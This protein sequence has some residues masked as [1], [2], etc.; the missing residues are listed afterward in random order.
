MPGF[1]FTESG[2]RARF[3]GSDMLLYPKPISFKL[4]ESSR[5]TAK[6]SGPIQ[7][8]CAQGIVTNLMSPGVEAYFPNSA[9]FKIKSIRGPILTVSDASYGP[10]TSTP[11][12]KWILLTFGDQQPPILFSFLG[13]QC[14]LVVQGKS[15][16]WSLQTA[17]PFVGWIRISLPFGTQGISANGPS[18]LGELAKTLQHQSTLWTQPTPRMVSRQIV[19]TDTSV[20]VRMRFDRASSLVPP[21]LILS[22]LGGYKAKIYSPVSELRAWNEN[23]PIVVTRTKELVFECPIQAISPGRPLTLGSASTLGATNEGKASIARVCQL[24]L[25]LLTS[26]CPE[27]AVDQ[28]RKMLS[29][30][31]RVD[32]NFDT[33]AADSLLWRGLSWNSKSGPKLV[34]ERLNALLLELDPLTFCFLGTDKNIARRASGICAISA[35]LDSKPEINFLGAMLQMGMRA[36][37]VL[38]SFWKAKSLDGTEVSNLEPMSKL[39]NGLFLQGPNHSFINTFK[40]P[41]KIAGPESVQVEKR[42]DSFLM[43]WIFSKDD[44]PQLNFLTKLK[45]DFEATDDLLEYEEQS[46]EEFLA[47]SY[48]PRKAGSCSIKFRAINGN[49]VLPDS[50]SPPAYSE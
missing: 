8:N 16:E 5:V 13:K 14:G 7:A 46:L 22:K 24:G 34:N 35:A 23:G 26:W 20:Q 48:K 36:E 1:I 42:S 18:A 32:K 43:R 15:G 11:E 6:Y 27:S 4:M 33:I 29:D 37:S 41:M 39:R 40:S 21:A 17:K 12:S 10:G 9:S 47:L 45:L 30:N 31:A 19:K 44:V 38:P 25:L 50:I 28:G 2:F 3:Q 49:L